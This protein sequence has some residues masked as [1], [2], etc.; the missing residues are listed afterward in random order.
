MFPRQLSQAVL[1]IQHLFTL[2][3]EPQNIQLV[4]DS[5][6]G[7][8]I[9]QVFSHILNPFEGVPKLRLTSPL[10]GAY[11]RPLTRLGDGKGSLLH[12]NIGRGDVID[13]SIGTYWRPNVLAITKPSAYSSD[14][15]VKY[16]Y[17]KTGETNLKFIR[18]QRLDALEIWHCNRSRALLKYDLKGSESSLRVIVFS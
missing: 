9:H 5:P 7:S 17:I 18:S 6:D 15:S 1:S 2:G 13:T 8:L 3:F 10:G 4:G 14:T 11:M 12:T 16:I